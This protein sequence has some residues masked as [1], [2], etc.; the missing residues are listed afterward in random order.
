MFYT[1]KNLTMFFKNV[2]RRAP[3]PPKRT[4]EHRGSQLEQR[5]SPPSPEIHAHND[6]GKKMVRL[7]IAKWN[8]IL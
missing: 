6:D 7:G 3:P 4:T 8:F 1:F 5:G 2:F